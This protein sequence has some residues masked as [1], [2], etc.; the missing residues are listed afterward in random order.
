MSNE[1]ISAFVLIP[2]SKK[3]DDI[4]KMGI[5]ETANLLDIKAERVDE[6][7]FQEGILEH[8]YR[9]I[10]AAD[11][12]IADMSGQNPNVFYEVGFAHAKEKLCIL[13]TNNS[14]DIPFDL[15]HHRHI[16][17]HDSISDL[18]EM[19]SRDLDWAR[20]QV[21]DVR[22][23]RIQVKLR[24]LS[25]NL[26]IDHLF[27]KAEVSFKIDMYNESSSP[28]SEIEAIY[29]YSQKDWTVK[30]DGK[31][32]PSTD[33]DLLDFKFRSFIT[34]PIKRLHK[35]SWAQ[36]QFKSSKYVSEKELDKGEF[37]SVHRVVGKSVL[38]LVTAEGD[39]DHDLP[40]DVECSDV[41][42]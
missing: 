3:F 13:L 26:E 34:P 20:S 12:I 36:L 22:N 38:R 35:K 31:E 40:I 15:K 8:I 9:Q 17:Y 11:I 42:F 24:K 2:F 10:E 29:L 6:Q 21:E 5:K 25:G 32:C 16:V 19:L 27:T 7:I 30:Q 41:P 23:S 37:W 14:E 33:S 1:S 28:S 39:Y 18:R 4:Y